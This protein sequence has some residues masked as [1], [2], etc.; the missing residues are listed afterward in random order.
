M[1]HIREFFYKK[2]YKEPIFKRIALVILAFAVMVTASSI[3]AA[4]MLEARLSDQA[5]AVVFQ[6][7]MNIETDFSGLM[8]AA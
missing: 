8:T 2:K 7:I 5:E 4:H 1:S 6:A 3:M